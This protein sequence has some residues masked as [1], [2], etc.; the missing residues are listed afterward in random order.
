MSSDSAHR[1]RKKG[2]PSN[3][4]Q[5]RRKRET[6]R[7]RP[8]AEESESIIFDATRMFFVSRDNQPQ[9]GGEGAPAPDANG[10]DR[11]GKGK[12]KPKP[13]KRQSVA[14]KAEYLNH[15]YPDSFTTREGYYDLVR[16]GEHRGYV[17]FCPPLQFTLARRLREQ[18]GLNGAADRRVQVVNAYRT[19]T[20]SD[21]CS[22]GAR[23]LYSLVKKHAA[24]RADRTVHLGL[25]IGAS[26]RKV[27][28]ILG[29][30]LRTDADSPNFVVHAFSPPGFAQRDDQPPVGRMAESLRT[31][32]N[33][34]ECIEI[35]AGPIVPCS[36]YQATRRMLAWSRAFVQRQKVDILVTALACARH[37]HAVFSHYLND[38]APPQLTD[39]TEKE[40]REKEWVGDVLCQPYSESGPI[41][42]QRGVRSVVLFDIPELV[43]L[44]RRP[45]KDIV[46]VA[47]P[48]SACQETR[49]EALRPLMR[50]ESLRVWNHLVTDVVTAYELLHGRPPASAVGR[51]PR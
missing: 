44:A 35:D 20:H 1:P 32:L 49:T 22:G 43:E 24:G 47:G 2:Q 23:L 31:G 28:R 26:A 29:D 21:V 10:S 25:S 51:L 39:E 40:L 16:E 5:P 30:I 6:K 27:T 42:P 19:T 7:R 41:S 33:R 46:L 9:T 8:V 48:C 17:L 36:D 18:Y 50:V 13:K 4:G 34:V 14:E 37:L 15:H 12:D 11:S 45:D 38:V 3:E